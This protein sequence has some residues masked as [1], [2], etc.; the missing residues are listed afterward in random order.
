M[1][2]IRRY[3]VTILIAMLTLTSFMA[4]L[5]SYTD[6]QR[7]HEMMRSIVEQLSLSEREKLGFYYAQ[8]EP[9]ASNLPAQGDAAAAQELAGGCNGCHGNDGNS[10]DKAVPSLAGQ[11]AVFLWGD[12]RRRVIAQE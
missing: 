2:S 10:T 6:G 8:Q 4:A 3:L 7:S 1:S 11:D 9:K 12:Q 5:Q